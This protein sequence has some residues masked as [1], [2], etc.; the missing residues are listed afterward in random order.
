MGIF[1]NLFGKKTTTMTS[2]KN[3]VLGGT[4]F[5]KANELTM[6]GEFKQAIT[7]Y[8]QAIEH[9]PLDAD[10]YE[11][12]YLGRAACFSEIHDYE[13]AL[14]DYSKAIQI[15]PKYLLA[16]SLR[17]ECYYNLKQYRNAVDDYEKALSL[18]FDSWHANAETQLVNNKQLPNNQVRF[19][20]H[21]GLGKAYNQLL[22][23]K[24]SL[25]HLEKAYSIQPS[26]GMASVIHDLKVR[27]KALGW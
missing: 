19:E 14:R 9:L 26:S 11:D 17:G 6:R 1:D 8:N 18:E 10:I 21:T 20:I 25:V 3:K 16:Y 12:C 23:F 27:I 24:N 13:S 2:T 5:M 4:A 15:N 7:S 22:D